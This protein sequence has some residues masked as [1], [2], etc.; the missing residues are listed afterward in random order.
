MRRLLLLLLASIL[1]AGLALAAP[2]PVILGLDHIPLAVRDL[3]QAARDFARLGFTVK[4]G[5]PHENGIRNL[6]L[7]FPDRTEIELITAPAARDELS[8]QYVHHLR[9]GDGPAFVAFYAPDFDALGMR[10]KALSLP[11]RRDWA[12]VAL[13][14]PQ[15]LFFSSRLASPTDNESYFT[16]ANGAYGLIGVWLAG[17]DDDQPL[18]AML[19][20]DLAANQPVNTP[21]PGTATVARLA[22]GEVVF[23][24]AARQLVPGRRIIGAVLKTHDLAALQ[25]A[26][27]AS[28]LPP[29]EPVMTP[30]GRSIFLPPSSAHGLWLEFREV[31]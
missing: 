12:T 9:D 7:K 8:G 26:M 22:E 3:E 1:T 4:P 10:L 27:K 11:F 30:H 19:G 16:H 24:P 28:G 20:T 29:P 6:H 21:E 14:S 5:R 13:E 18:L 2:A 17:P 15:H 31:R 23:L 25:A